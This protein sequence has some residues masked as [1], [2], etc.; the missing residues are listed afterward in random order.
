MS[1]ELAKYEIGKPSTVAEI[2]AE[3]QL[4]QDILTHIMIKD[5]HYGTIPGTK[6]PTLYKPGSEKIL[7]TFHIGVDPSENVQDLST[8]D[9]I[10]Y[11]V[12]LRAFNQATGSTIGYGVGECSSNEEKYRWRRPVCENEFDEA[13]DDMKRVVWRVGQKG[14]YQAKQVRTNPA[15][16]ANTILKMSK[17]RAQIDLTLTVTAASDVFEQDLEDIPQEVRE[18]IVE[19]SKGEKPDM[20][21]PKEKKQQEKKSGDPSVRD[22][23]IKELEEYCSGDAEMMEDVIQQCSFFEKDGKPHSFSVAEVTATKQD[24]S[25]KISDAWVGKALGVLRD[26]VKAEV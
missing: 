10:R 8:P 16:V 12:Y 1:E 13:P 23:L 2:K 4:I 25:P 19:N 3:V 7:R 26:M 18:G 6:K 5:V 22:K 11:R 24:G 20:T 21:P 14:P 15:D 17:K 9:E